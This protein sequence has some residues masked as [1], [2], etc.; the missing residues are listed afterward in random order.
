MSIDVDN[1]WKDSYANGNPIWGKAVK[2]NNSVSLEKEKIKRGTVPDVKGMG[3][4]DAVFLL[5]TLGFKVRINGIGQ[6]YEQSID[7]G[8]NYSKGEFISLRLK[9]APHRKA[10]VVKVKE[11]TAEEQQ[12]AHID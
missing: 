12:N 7:P 3:A 4:R 11:P 10:N 8:K 9:S 2:H 1:G 5:E 6:V